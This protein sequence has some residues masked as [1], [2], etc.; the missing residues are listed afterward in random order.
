MT[1]LLKNR[2]ILSV[3]GND[4]LIFLQNLTTNDLSGNSYSYNY[5]L[6]PQG[7]YLYDFFVLKFSYSKLFIDIDFSS[8]QFLLKKLNLYKLRSNIEINDVTSEYCILYSKEKLKITD[9]I[10]FS[11]QDPRFFRLGFRSLVK[12]GYINMLELVNDDLYVKDKYEFTIPDG[13]NDLIFDNS[14]ASHFGA[15]ELSAIS[16]SKG[17]Y[18]GQE[19]ISRMKYQGTARKKLFKISCGTKIALKELGA[20]ITDLQG[21]KIGIFCSSYNN[22]GIALLNEEKYL[23]LD[24]KIAII[25]NAQEVLILTPEW[26]K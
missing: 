4:A 5:L 20:E 24:K 18:V 19:V 7:R 25:K 8:S 21:E 14:L 23:G 15:E 1:Q 22:L 17:C 9:K 2:A 13:V 12:S 10:I 3:T 6:S 11:Y 16:F 26:R